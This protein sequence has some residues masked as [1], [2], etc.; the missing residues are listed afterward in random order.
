M[1]ARANDGNGNLAWVY[2]WRDEQP[3]AF[4]AASGGESYSDN[5]AAVGTSPGTTAFKAKSGDTG[6]LESGFIY[7]NVSIVNRAPTVSASAAS[8]V[9]GQPITVN[10]SAGDP[11]GNFS[12]VQVWVTQWGSPYW[13]YIGS[14]GASGSTQWSSSAH[15]NSNN[16]AAGAYLF[17][18]RAN[19]AAGA[20]AD[21]Y[22]TFDITN[23]APDSPNITGSG[24]GVT[25]NSTGQHYEMWVDN[26]IA[27]NATLH[28]VD[29]NL[30]FH[31]IYHNNGTGITDG[32]TW[33]QLTNGT[34]SNGTNSTLSPTYTPLI[35][36][37]WDFHTNGRDVAGV[38]AGGASITAYV[39]GPTNNAQFVSQTVKGLPNPSSV[40][41]NPG[42]QYSVSITMRNNGEKPWTTDGTPHKLGAAGNGQVSPDTVALPVTV[43]NPLPQTNSDAT[44]NFTATAPTV[45]GNYTL[46]WRMLEDG[47]QWFG[48]YTPAVTITVANVA[49]VVVSATGGTIAYGQSFDTTL[50]ATDANADLS[51]FHLVVASA[52]FNSSAN[53]WEGS[54]PDGWKWRHFRTNAVSGSDATITVPVQDYNYGTPNPLPVGTYR[55]TLNAQDSLPNYTYSASNVLATLIVAKATPVGTFADRNFSGTHT[56]TAG[57]LNAAFANPYSGSVAAPTGPATYRVVN[58]SGPLASPTSGAITVG[59]V[60]RAGSY[61]IRAEYPGDANYTSAIKDASFTVSLDPNADDDGDG[62][63]NSLETALGLNPYDPADVSVSIYTYDKINQLKTGPGGQYIKDAEGNIK[64]VLP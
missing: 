33:Q 56:L 31:A 63:S 1:Q 12:N 55:L 22:A 41:V 37:R 15:F 46:M 18:V 9:A 48:A 34:P 44:F 32:S 3:F 16:P 29:G 4:N 21:A 13:D 24:A 19:D 50:R 17:V 47:V 61:V 51:Y 14:F 42:E 54:S 36:G 49:P 62:V 2:V 45:P 35:P 20:Y 30:S 38:W 60:L 59:T 23:Q 52:A 8:A 57:D 11:D 10:W 26:P 43:V 39:Y 64:Q 27:L 58:A 5:N 6:G 25:Y 53:N 28:D 40:T 7:H